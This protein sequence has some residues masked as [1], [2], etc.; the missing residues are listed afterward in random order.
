MILLLATVFSV[1]LAFTVPVVTELL[2][3]VLSEVALFPVVALMAMLLWRS[4]VLD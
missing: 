3:L 1:A 2:P 4:R